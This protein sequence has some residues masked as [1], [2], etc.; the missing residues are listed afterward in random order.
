MSCHSLSSY[1]VGNSTLPTAAQYYVH[2][3]LQVSPARLAGRTARYAAHRV[4]HE[5]GRRGENAQPLGEIHPACRIDLDEGHAVT[6]ARHGGK[7]FSC[8]PAERA[9]IGGELDEGRLPPERRAK[10]GGGQDVASRRG[11]AELTLATAQREASRARRDK[12]N[13]HRYQATDHA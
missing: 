5:D 12:D 11:P 4:E 2:G 7:Q 1:L 13:R 10:V 8:R 6:L 3:T 9:E